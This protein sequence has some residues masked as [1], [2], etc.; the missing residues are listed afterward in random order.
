MCVHV[1]AC[2]CMSVCV[3]VF[4]RVCVCVCC[5]CVFVCSDFLWGNHAIITAID[6]TSND[7]FRL[8]EAVVIAEIYESRREGGGVC[9]DSFCV[10]E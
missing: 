1:C 4:V 2:A 5:V 7:C 8:D 10:D 3:F 9:D 6:Y